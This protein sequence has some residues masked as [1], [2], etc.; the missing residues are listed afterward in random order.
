MNDSSNV[1]VKNGKLSNPDLITG[2][3]GSHPIGTGIGAAAGGAAAG[4][5]IGT[6]AGPAGTIAGAALGAIVGGLAGKSV[7][8][9]VNPTIEDAY[10]RENHRLQSYANG[11]SY[12]DYGPA[13]RN[14]Y[15]GYE[16]YGTDGRSFAEREAEL[17]KRYEATRPKLAWTE[18]RLASQ[19]AWQ[20]IEEQRLAAVNR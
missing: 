15:E 13:Y 18:G 3:P 14:G 4:A 11:R 10:W 9:A 12:D 17:R 1:A 5:A 20:R 6:V 7:A 16:Q 2:A 19:A 8:E